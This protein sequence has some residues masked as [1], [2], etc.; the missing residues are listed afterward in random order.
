M[1]QAI[2]KRAR[3]RS[4]DADKLEAVLLQIEAYNWTI[5][6][7]IF[8]FFLIPHI[9]IPP[10]VRGTQRLVQGPKQRS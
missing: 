2:G 8:V 1:E 7:S 6:F 9:D 4:S 10:P 3:T 5:A